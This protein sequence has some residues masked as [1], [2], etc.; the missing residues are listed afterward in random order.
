MKYLVGVVIGIILFVIATSMMGC[1][2]VHPTGTTVVTH[3]VTSTPVALKN[4]AIGLDWIIVLAVVAVGIGVGCFFTL[5][6]AHNL[7]LS[8]AVSAGAIE[9]SALLARVSLWFV[10]WL[11]GGLAAVA[12]GIF[13]YEVWRNRA[14]IESKLGLTGLDATVAKLEAKV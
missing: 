6:A 12:L 14:A 8:I 5:P 4:V 13:C 7:S 11:A 3:S 2:A 10:P 9:V 1:A